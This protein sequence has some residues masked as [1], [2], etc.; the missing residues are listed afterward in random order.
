MRTSMFLVWSMAASVAIAAPGCGGPQSGTGG[1]EQPP[2]TREDPIVLTASCPSDLPGDPYQLTS[3]TLDGELLELE[4]QY[5]G[6]CRA[7][8][9]VACWPENT[10]AESF[11]VQT[12]L[13][14]Y[15]DAGGDTCEALAMDTRYVDISA[16]LTAYQ[17][18]YGGSGPIVMHVRDTDVSVTY[19]PP[20]A[21]AAPPL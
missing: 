8:R 13:A 14:L 20:D 19:Q 1:D 5:P 2:G 6:G 9:F 15:H 16:I 4:L 11:P 17:Q 3:A 7:H 12:W 10:F 18:A 21:P